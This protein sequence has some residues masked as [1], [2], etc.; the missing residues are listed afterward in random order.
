MDEH[1][2]DV[3]TRRDGRSSPTAEYG[4]TARRTVEYRL[5]GAGGRRDG[6]V[7][8]TGRRIGEGW[9]RRWQRRE[10]EGDLRPDCRICVFSRRQ[11]GPVPAFLSSGVPE[12]APRDRG[13]SGLAGWI[14]AKIRAKTR[15]R[16]RDWAE[17]HSPDVKNGRR[18]PS[19]GTAGDAL[20]LAMNFLSWNIPW[21]CWEFGVVARPRLRS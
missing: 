20:N 19:R 17:Y 18:G 13:W 15:N 16:G 11:S 4:Q 9:C 14:K 8:A 1:L 2:P 7:Q 6:E 21:N 3:S 12:R 10:G 5:V